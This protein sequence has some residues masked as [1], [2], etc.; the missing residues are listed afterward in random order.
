[1][2]L[3]QASLNGAGVLQDFR[4]GCQLAFGVYHIAYHIASLLALQ[5]GVD[6]D[7]LIQ[8]NARS[9]TSRR[10]SGGPGSVKYCYLLIW[11]ATL[12]SLEG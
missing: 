10:H 11:E 3:S 6:F 7:V 8:A 4:L 1:M 5:S 12:N 2:Q 9:A